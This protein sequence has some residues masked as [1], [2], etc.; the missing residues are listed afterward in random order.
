MKNR[1]RADYTEKQT[2]EHKGSGFREFLDLARK[3]GAEGLPI[4]PP[5]PHKHLY[6]T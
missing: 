4:A 6:D 5:N 1:F 3:A 2:V